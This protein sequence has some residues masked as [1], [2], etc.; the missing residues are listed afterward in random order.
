MVS[1]RPTYI[2]T[3]MFKG[4]PKLVGPR[5]GPWGVKVPKAA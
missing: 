1:V 5:V 3:L 2:F 4:C